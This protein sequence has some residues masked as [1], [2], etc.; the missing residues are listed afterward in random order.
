MD[1]QVAAPIPFPPIGS[2]E[3]VTRI[4]TRTDAM[5]ESHRYADEA[6]EVLDPELL[7]TKEYCIGQFAG[8][9]DL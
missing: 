1:A 9:G 2:A 7:Y 8:L 6:N 5:A 3:P 4:H